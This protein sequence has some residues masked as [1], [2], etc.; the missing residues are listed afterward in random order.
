MRKAITGGLGALALA[1]AGPGPAQQPPAIGAAPVTLSSTPYVFD[2]AEQH[3]IKVTVVA[4]GLARPFAIEFLPN[5]DLLVNE[6]G[7]GLHV[8]R[9]ATQ[10]SARLDPQAIEGMPRPPAGSA[11]S[12]GFQDMALAPD[13]AKSHWLYFTYNE[14]APR[15]AGDN[16]APE[17]YS[18][19]RLTVMR[20]KL[21]GG[22][23]TGIQTLLQGGASA[24]LGSRLAFARDGTLFVTTGGAFGSTSQELGT[25]YGKVLHLNADG[26]IPK[27]NP[28]VG[29]TG[30]H[31]AVYSYGHRDQHGLVVHPVTGDVISAEHGPNGGDEVNLIKSGRNY[32]WPNYSYGR[33][34]DG[35]PLADNPV[36]PGIE[37]P[38]LVWLPSIAPSGLLV[39]QGDK[40]PAWKGNLFVG[41]ARWGEIPG[42]GSLQRVVF[43]ETYGEMRREALLSEL[44]QRV[45]D[46]AEGPDGLIY[47]LTDGPENAVLRI[48]PAAP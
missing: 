20:G 31:P 22:K 33:N 4:K 17:L 10:P 9:D 5:G 44:H 45:R 38:L 21:E 14:P 3:Q 25:I 26:S 39:Y 18:F 19:G 46:I 43:N 40:F 1:L 6:R 42:T 34:Y 28:F 13:F 32:G 35:A 16:A 27:D 15:P 30:A 36:G 23:L 47:V 8:I 29:K 41:S 12:V 7:G 11:F 48:E 37:K 2:T 24:A